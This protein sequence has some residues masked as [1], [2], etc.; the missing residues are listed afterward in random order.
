M[1]KNVFL[2]FILLAFNHVFAQSD[3]DLEL[4]LREAKQDT[5]R[6]RIY[7]ELSNDIHNAKNEEYTLAAIKLADKLILNESLDNKAI[8]KQKSIALSN[9]GLTYLNKSDFK[10]AIKYFNNSLLIETS[11]KN[12]DRQAE[13]NSYLALVYKNRN[14]LYESLRYYDISLKIYQDLEAKD[15]ESSTL[16][17]IA[18]VYNLKGD[19]EKSLAYYKKCED[20]LVSNSNKNESAKLNLNYG[21]VYTNQGKYNEARRCYTKSLDYYQM[22]GDRG[23]EANTL[24]HFGFS[25]EKEDPNKA[26]NYYEKSLKISKSLDDKFAMVQS[27]VSMAYVYEGQNKSKKAIEYYTNSSKLSKE[28]G[29]RQ[30][31]AEANFNIEKLKEKK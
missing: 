17:S 9:L 28:I 3:N 1:R 10:N 20:L 8:N 21:D 22:N 26:I 24:N 7:A 19:Y 18:S 23:G 12:G 6:L 4:E 25:Y 11:L 2:I 27:Y 29:Y 13:L 31:V 15:K 16:Q 14:E 5:T 30:G